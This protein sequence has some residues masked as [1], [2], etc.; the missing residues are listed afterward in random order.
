MAK[1]ESGGFTLDDVPRTQISG[2]SITPPDDLPMVSATYELTGGEIA[3]MGG[4]I[5]PLLSSDNTVTF[6]RN[7]RGSIF[8]VPVSGEDIPTPV[9]DEISRRLDEQMT[10]VEV[11]LP[12]FLRSYS[13]YRSYFADQSAPLTSSVTIRMNQLSDALEETDQDSPD[14]I[15]ELL[16]LFRQ[17]EARIRRLPESLVS[18]VPETNRNDAINAVAQLGSLIQQLQS[19]DRDPITEL[20]EARP[21]FLFISSDPSQW[22]QGEYSL[23]SLYGEASITGDNAGRSAQLLLDLAGLNVNVLNSAS[24]RYALDLLDDASKKAG[25]QLAKFWNQEPIGIR[26]QLSHRNGNLIIYIE[27]NDHRGLPAQRSYGF[28]WYLEFLLT[29]TAAKRSGKQHIL[30][31]D[32]PGIHL[33]P[34]GQEDL[35]TLLSDEAKESLQVIFTTHL[36]GMVD[37]AHIERIRGIIKGDTKR[38]GTW[39]VND[40]YSPDHKRVTWEVVLKALG[41]NT[42]AY[43]PS[44]TVLVEGLSDRQYLSEMARYMSAEDTNAALFST[45]A[46]RIHPGTGTKSW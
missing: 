17:L 35:K 44:Q 34:K 10:K 12:R 4:G 32:E 39:I 43:G 40:E 27:S 3:A 21:R 2:A 23:N 33:H 11:L 29:H 30:L 18:E 28:R 15:E 20:I 16:K 14:E 46:I 6:R 31:F 42:T 22:L 8:A 37:T 41:G 38:P 13:R 36:P 19:L 45:G 25:E 9:M 24:D 5:L 26:F 7:Y 1:F